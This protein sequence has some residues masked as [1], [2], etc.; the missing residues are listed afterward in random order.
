MV[1]G[2][3]ISV[4]QC[5]ESSS[6][7]CTTHTPSLAEHRTTR[8]N[9][10]THAAGQA[11]GIFFHIRPV[12]SS[13]KALGLTARPLHQCCRAQCS[14]AMNHVP[15]GENLDLCLQVTLVQWALPRRRFANTGREANRHVSYRGVARMHVCSVF[16]L[17]VQPEGSVAGGLVVFR[18][19]PCVAAQPSPRVSRWRC[20]RSGQ[21]S[22]LQRSRAR[23]S[24]VPC[25][26]A[27]SA[28]LIACLR[29]LGMLGAR[30]DSHGHPASADTT[31]FSRGGETR[32]RRIW[33]SLYLRATHTSSPP[34]CPPP[35]GTTVPPHSGGG[36]SPNDG[37]PHP[38]GGGGGDT[39][40][41]SPEF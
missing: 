13:S 12:L 27:L 35:P 34:P 3:L 38:R 28:L 14:Q 16:R 4:H 9:D 20:L 30:E 40:Q 33:A 41:Q 10:W 15:R 17:R 19:A 24:G 26:R 32:G 22:R 37:C 8:G 29:P 7:F 5:S 2:T 11:S 21:T 23:E 18:A 1:H 6:S 36:L 39:T 25:S 31:R